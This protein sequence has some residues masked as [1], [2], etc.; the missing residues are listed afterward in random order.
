MPYFLNGKQ[1]RVGKSFRGTD[2]TWY[3]NTFLRNA[4]QDQK[5]AVGVTW[6]ADPVPVDNRFYWSEN[7]PKSLEDQNVTDE[8]GDPVL[9][10]DGNQVVNKGL[11]TQWVAKQKKIAGSLLAPTDWY[12]TR[13]AEDSTATIPDAVTTYRAAVRTVSGQREAQITAAETF[14]AFVALVTNPSTVQVESE[15]VDEF[16]LSIWNTVPNPEP[17]LTLWPEEP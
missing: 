8:N 17:F 15:E 12:V 9:D 2:G 11:K 6:E 3:P 10:E 7:N 1:L 5:D 13:K 4:T 16:G 14:D